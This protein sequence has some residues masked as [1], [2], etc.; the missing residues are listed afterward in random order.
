MGDIAPSRALA[1]AAL[2][3]AGALI[4]GAFIASR[5]EIGPVAYFISA[6]IYEIGSLVCHQRPERSFHLWGAQLAV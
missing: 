3:W 5:P 1:A 2:L 6:A 4:L